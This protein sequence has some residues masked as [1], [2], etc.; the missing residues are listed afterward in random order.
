MHSEVSCPERARVMS[1]ARDGHCMLKSNASW[2]KVEWET[3]LHVN[4]MTDRYITFPQF[5]WRMVKNL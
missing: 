1:G 3:C 2:I 4:R 5:C